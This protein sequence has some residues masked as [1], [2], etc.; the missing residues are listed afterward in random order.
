MFT[1]LFDILFPSFCL[2]CKRR[3]HGEVLCRQCYPTLAPRGVG[4]CTRCQSLTTELDSSRHCEGCRLLPL[5]I[6]EIRYLWSYEGRARD[7]ITCIKYKPSYYLAKLAGEI[8]KQNYRELF[9]TP[10]WDLLVPIPTSSQSLKVRPFN[11]C[12]LMGRAINERAP[13]T[14][15]ALR[16]LGCRAPQAS[17]SP[18]DRLKNVRGAF[19]ADPVVV[20]GREI[21]LIDDVITT[22]ATYSAATKALLD[23][24]AVRVSLL[25]LARSPSWQEFRALTYNID[26]PRPSVNA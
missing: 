4:C 22:G 12:E 16:H 24:G 1:D 21:L 10:N 2:I 6:H 14:K 20:R 11:L 23:A 18:E 15:K 9:H 17:L 26:T 25:A 8:L 19:L 7:L 3:L 13:L 5:P